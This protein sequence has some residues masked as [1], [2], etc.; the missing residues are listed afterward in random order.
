M[1]DV[2]TGHLAF[3]AH[4]TFAELAGTFADAAAIGVDIPIGLTCTRPRLADVKARRLMP[5]KGSSVFP[6]PHPDIRNEREYAAASAR[7]R[8]LV[9]KDLSKQGFA[10]L[11]K[12][13]EVNEYLTP[14]LQEH[15]V[16]VH[17]EVSFTELNG[18]TPVLARKST[19]A[20][21]AERRALLI[22]GSG[23]APMPDWGGV[24][25]APRAGDRFPRLAGADRL[26]TLPPAPPPH[27]DARSAAGYTLDAVIRAA[28]RSRHRTSCSMSVCRPYGSLS[29]FVAGFHRSPR[30]P[31]QPQRTDR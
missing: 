26:L 29:R 17:P 3:S 15:I 1:G 8:L 6:A 9:G 4:A 21:F 12:I 10:I 19:A 25:V 23:F 28:L 2:D 24:L 16:E 31:A 13:A 20:G 5:G 14:E 7:S 11:P 22:E 18:G 27:A 30:S